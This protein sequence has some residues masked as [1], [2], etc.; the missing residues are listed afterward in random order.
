MAEIA[1]KYLKPIARKNRCY[2]MTKLLYESECHIIPR[3]S[4]VDSTLSKSL[5][6]QSESFLFSSNVF[7]RILVGNGS[8]EVRAGD[9]AQQDV[10]FVK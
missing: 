6:E 10:R 1:E 3:G 4:S 5:V 2:I 8:I 7:K 9:I